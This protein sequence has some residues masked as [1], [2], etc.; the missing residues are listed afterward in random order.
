MDEA[1]SLL[2][3]ERAGHRCE[4]CQLHQDDSRITFEVDCAHLNKR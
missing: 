3:W 4:Y 1:L 2:V